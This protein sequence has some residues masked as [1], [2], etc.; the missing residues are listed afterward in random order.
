[1]DRSSPE[2]KLI[3]KTY[4]EYRSQKPSGRTI[5]TQDPDSLVEVLGNELDGASPRIPKMNNGS[6][7]STL[8]DLPKRLPGT[9]A[10]DFLKIGPTDIST[11]M[12]RGPGSKITPHLKLLFMR[13]RARVHYRFN[14]DCNLCKIDTNH[15][16]FRKPYTNNRSWLATR[17]CYVKLNNSRFESPSRRILP[18]S[19]VPTCAV[20]C[21]LW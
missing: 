17:R 18:C 12:P 20:V 9:R 2:M 11:A 4:Q 14:G 15:A 19:S 1:M 6:M 13:F 7:T 8:L 5:E 21:F 3:L 10:G 16:Q